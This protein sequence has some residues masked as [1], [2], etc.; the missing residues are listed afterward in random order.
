VTN[1]V[2]RKEGLDSMRLPKKFS[3]ILIARCLFAHSL[4]TILTPVPILSYNLLLIFS[5]YALLYSSSIHSSFSCLAG[6]SIPITFSGKN[7]S[8]TSPKTSN[9]PHLPFTS[10]RSKYRQNYLPLVWHKHSALQ[11][12]QPQERSKTPLQNRVRF[13]CPLLDK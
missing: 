4:I 9:P 12:P 7:R 10:H 6:F 13:P 3:I 5:I 8:V 2:G 1:R 11:I